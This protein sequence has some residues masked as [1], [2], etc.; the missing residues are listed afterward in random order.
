M[1]FRPIC[2]HTET[3]EKE[4]EEERKDRRMGRREGGKKKGRMGRK[5]GGKKGRRKERS[6]NIFEIK[7]SLYERTYLSEKLNIS[8]YST[9]G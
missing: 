2:L 3:V 5:E 8:D 6:K 4:R 1:N 7:Q 9:V